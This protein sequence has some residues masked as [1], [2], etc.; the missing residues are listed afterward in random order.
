MRARRLV[1][2]RGEV[3][4]R[5]VEDGF[6]SEHKSRRGGV[7]AEGEEREGGRGGGRG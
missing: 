7:R 1:V 6:G 5:G 3:G 2:R 4:H